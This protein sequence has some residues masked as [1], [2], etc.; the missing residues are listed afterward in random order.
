MSSHLGWKVF[1]TFVRTVIQTAKRES[2]KIRGV[3]DCFPLLRTGQLEIGQ[4]AELALRNPSQP[5]GIFDGKSYLCD[6]E[7]LRTTR[8]RLVMRGV[9]LK[10][11]QEI[12][13]TKRLQ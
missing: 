2:L 4:R 10:I 13:G 9:H 12:M 11:V 8:N 1:S 7:G 5:Q 6:V 3:T